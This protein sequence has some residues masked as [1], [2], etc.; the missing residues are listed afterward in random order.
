M[1]E[2][3]PK[4]TGLKA[5][6]VTEWP[7]TDEFELGACYKMASDH[8]GFTC[9][10]CGQFGSVRAASIKP[11]EGPSWKIETG[12]LDDPTTLTLSPSINCVGCCGWHGYLRN[13]VF[14]SC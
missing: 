4:R 13:G 7:E 2:K 11:A 9:P 12:S 5:F 8:I 3:N 1:I 10:G 6:K 14:E